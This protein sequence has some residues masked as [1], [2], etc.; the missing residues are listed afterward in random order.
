MCFITFSRG[1]ENGRKSVPLHRKEITSPF[2]LYI[3]EKPVF[4]VLRKYY[5]VVGGVV[6]PFS[7]D[8]GDILLFG[9]Y[10]AAKASAIKWCGQLSPRVSTLCDCGELSAAACQCDNLVMQCRGNECFD[11]A[12]VRVVA[13]VYQKYVL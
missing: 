9:S 2:A 3:M 6:A 4:V 8:G 10:D 11:N 12:Y 7:P 5:H 13:E 1:R